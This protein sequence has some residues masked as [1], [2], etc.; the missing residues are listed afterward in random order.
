MVVTVEPGIYV[1][2]DHECDP[3]WSGIGV[4][5]ED[6]ILCTD[7]DPETLTAAI[8]READAIEEFACRNGR[9]GARL[10]RRAR[11]GRRRGPASSAFTCARR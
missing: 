9:A 11:S 3:R 2:R 5:I 7:G 1:A 8:P 10:I 4:R 6:D